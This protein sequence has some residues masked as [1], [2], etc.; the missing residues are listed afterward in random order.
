MVMLSPSDLVR[1]SGGELFGAA[2]SP[3]PKLRFAAIAQRPCQP[4]DVIAFECPQPTDHFAWF[5]PRAGVPN[6]KA[7]RAG[8]ESSGASPNLEREG[9]FSSVHVSASFMGEAIS[10]C[11]EALAVVAVSPRMRARANPKVCC[12]G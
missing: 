4:Y 6:A 8:H 7:H 10:F 2:L 3:K 1:P 11:E 12:S 5:D 9:A